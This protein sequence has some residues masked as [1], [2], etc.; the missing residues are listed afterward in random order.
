MLTIINLCTKAI[1]VS[2]LHEVL[3]GQLLGG[4]VSIALSK[5]VLAFFS[6]FLILS[7]LH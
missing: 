3:Q 6:H 5:R 1:R 4:H 7:I 2:W